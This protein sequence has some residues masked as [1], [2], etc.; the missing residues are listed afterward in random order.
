ME[1]YEQIPIGTVYAGVFG[2]RLYGLQSPTSDWDIKG[3]FIPPKNKLYGLW[4]EGKKPSGIRFENE[5]KSIECEFLDIREFLRLCNRNN[6]TILDILFG[7]PGRHFGKDGAMQLRGVG[8]DR[9]EL[10]KLL[11][12]LPDKTWFQKKI[13]PH[14][15]RFLSQTVRHSYGSYALA[16]IKRIERHL[17]WIESPPTEPVLDAK[18]GPVTPFD[19]VLHDEKKKKW[20]NYQEWRANRNTDRAKLE[21]EFGYDTKHAMHLYRLL[22]VGRSILETGDLIHPRSD[23]ELTVLRDIRGGKYSYDELTQ[24]S[25]EAFE[26]L[27]TIPSDLPEK[28]NTAWVIDL[29]VELIDDYYRENS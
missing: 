19:R 1:L 3:L 11:T 21:T 9:G 16:Q 17:K 15:K 13:W 29:C 26:K 14:R 20:E 4:A 6:P 7:Q 8:E 12:S 5:S 2:S 25:Y 28:N 24:M 10:V 22:L 27:E 18:L 23:E